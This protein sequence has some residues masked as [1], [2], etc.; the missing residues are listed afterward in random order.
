ME[1]QYILAIDRRILNPPEILS[2]KRINFGTPLRK[3]RFKGKKIALE[4]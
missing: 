4:E 2:K 1:I 3:G